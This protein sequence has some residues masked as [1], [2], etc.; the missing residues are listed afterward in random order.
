MGA[1][2]SLQK[3]V[4]E[5]APD[6]LKA[7]LEHIAFISVKMDDAQN[8]LTATQCLAQLSEDHQPIF[9]EMAGRYRE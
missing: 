3:I 9:G 5:Q 2:D 8:A 7:A 6:T 4:E 1:L